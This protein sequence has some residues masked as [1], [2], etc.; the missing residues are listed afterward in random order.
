MLKIKYYTAIV[1]LI[2]FVI[3]SCSKNDLINSDQTKVIFNIKGVG[4]TK[5][6]N[7]DPNQKVAN[8]IS[9]SQHFKT[10]I[11]NGQYLHVDITPSNTSNLIASTTSNNIIEPVPVDTRYRIVVYDES[12]NYVNHTDE[13][14]G[15]TTSPSITLPAG[16]NYKFL[17]YTFLT[18]DLPDW[19]HSEYT[20]DNFI[21]EINE[22][23]DESTDFT[24]FIANS[25]KLVTGE[26]NIN[27][28]LR[29]NFTKLSI[30]MKSTA[31][32]IENITSAEIDKV[33][34][35]ALVIPNETSILLLGEPHVMYLPTFEN[36]N[37][38]EVYS[39]KKLL[40]VKDGDS[41]TLTFRNVKIA[42]TG[43]KEKITIPN[44]ILRTGVQYTATFT[45]TKAK[46]ELDLGL[47]VVGS[48]VKW[49]PGNLIYEN[50]QYK[51]AKDQYTIGNYWIW[52]WL[53]PRGEKQ[54]MEN[55][56]IDNELKNGYDINRDPC[57]KVNNGD[58]TKWRTPSIND[59]A[60]IIG[61]D[62]GNPKANR[63]LVIQKKKIG[64]DNVTGIYFGVVSEKEVTAK[65]VFLP[66][67]G[68]YQSNP[69]TINKSESYSTGWYQ[70]SEKVTNNSNYRG[71][72]LSLYAQSWQIDDF[73]YNQSN[74]F[75]AATPIRCVRAN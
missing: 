29:Q 74:Y 48:D 30:V 20:L 13:V 61:K 63:V 52:N 12:G 39:P 53:T 41:H 69:P 7:T 49:A 50:G 5:Q 8:T 27:V 75:Q 15:G 36:L 14:I 25:T 17:I 57:T 73:L 21:I 26:N 31:G 10:A 72:N 64:N 6:S 68:T 54:K 22:D 62:P 34:K 46:N 37:T 40:I 24:Y 55:W 33:Y 71:L 44:I 47:V 43:I 19:A 70:S 23:I 4:S 65:T 32:I 58:G 59:Y 45:I 28:I 2:S 35:S 56:Q 1:L 9:K 66:Y 51:F 18:K 11:G 60:S 16:I 38:T 67:G 3:S 42:G